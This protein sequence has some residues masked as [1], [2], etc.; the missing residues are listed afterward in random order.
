M[1]SS[2]ALLNMPEY[3]SMCLNKQ[4]SECAVGPEYATILN[5]EGFW[6]CKS[7]TGF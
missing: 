2:P 5:I 1:F 4:N 6:I 7:Y 3:A